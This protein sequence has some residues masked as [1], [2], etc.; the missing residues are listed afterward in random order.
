MTRVLASILFEALEYDGL[1]SILFLKSNFFPNA[2][3]NY[4]NGEC[5]CGKVRGQFP[6][7]NQKAAMELIYGPALQNF[8]AARLKAGGSQMFKRSQTS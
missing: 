8:L 4:F 2:S 3:L 7:L 5:G 6:T 1:I